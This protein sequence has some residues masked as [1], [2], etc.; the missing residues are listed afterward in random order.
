MWAVT[1]NHPDIVKL[2]VARSADVK[3]QTTITMPRAVRPAR[4]PAPPGRASS[5][6]ARCPRRTA[7]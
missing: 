7:A 2:L 3:A 4:R 1:E 5:V 6:S